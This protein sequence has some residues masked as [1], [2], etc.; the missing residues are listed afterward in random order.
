MI[1]EGVIAMAIKFSYKTPKEATIGKHGETIETVKNVV[2]DGATT[3]ELVN[4][5]KKYESKY[6]LT[7]TITMKEPKN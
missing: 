3:E 4:E 1:A 2:F 7:V 5:I 6:D